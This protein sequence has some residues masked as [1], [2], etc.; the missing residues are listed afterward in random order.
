[1]TIQN[2]LK[3]G[4][5]G[6]VLIM[7]GCS[8]TKVTTQKYPVE[9]LLSNYDGWSI[10]YTD[11]NGEVKENRLCK[12]YGNGGNSIRVLRDLEDSQDRFAEV[13]DYNS[14]INGS[15]Y[16]AIIHI[17]K[18]DRISGGDDST[19]GKNPIHHRRNKMKLEEEK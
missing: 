3:A 5:V 13:T 8:E 4:L 12:G 18:S 2:M 19:G 16:N 14:G 1:M 11:K 9:D 10:F 7:P 15:H 6:L 17:R